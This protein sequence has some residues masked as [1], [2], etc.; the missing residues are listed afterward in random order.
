MKVKV[1]VFGIAREKA[2]A[3]QIFVDLAE[4]ATLADL[5]TAISRTYPD[6]ASVMQYAF[7][8]NQTYADDTCPLHESD[9]IALI[10][11]VSGG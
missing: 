2:G 11:P 1:L 5:R 9:E 10:P 6:L 3:P 7:A 8:V 4:N